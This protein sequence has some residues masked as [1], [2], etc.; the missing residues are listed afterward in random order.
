MIHLIRP[1]PVLVHCT[2]TPTQPGEPGSTSDSHQ[3]KRNNNRSIWR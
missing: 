2:S 3:I 1:T